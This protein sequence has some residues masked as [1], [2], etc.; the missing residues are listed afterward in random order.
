MLATPGFCDPWIF[1]GFRGRKIPSNPMDF[2]FWGF[3][4]VVTA[5]DISALNE[6]ALYGKPYW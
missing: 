2:G 4:G 3:L 5:G 6:A 1:G